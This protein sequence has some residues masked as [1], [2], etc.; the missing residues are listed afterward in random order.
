MDPFT[1]LVNSVNKSLEKRKYHNTSDDPEVSD[2]IQRVRKALSTLNDNR[3]E[4]MRL[5]Y[6]ENLTYVEIAN[7]TDKSE[8]SIEKTLY[9]A[10]KQLESY[11]TKLTE[12]TE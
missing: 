8:A 3:R 12:G 2:H 10:R 5:K 1:N 6:E 7:R 11:L 9:R 4:L